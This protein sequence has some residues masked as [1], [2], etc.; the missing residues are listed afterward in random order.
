MKILKS[1]NNVL[2]AILR[3]ELLLRLKVDRIFIHIVYLLFVVWTTLYVS[4]KIEQTLLKVEKNR[5]EIENLK[6]YHA[7]KSCELAEY[8]R[9][10]KVQDMLE[11]MGSD[12]T[13]PTK[14]AGRI[15]R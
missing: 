9:I 1:I 3:G 15:V 11:E 8:D 10:G 13:L 12:V 6:I 5:T 4:L 14:P 7:Q 2:V